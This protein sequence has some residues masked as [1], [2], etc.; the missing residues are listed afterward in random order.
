[1]PIH[2]NILLVL[3]LQF[4]MVLLFMLSQKLNVSYPIFLVIGGLLIGLIPGVPRITLQPDIV[5]LL[6]LPPL[7]YAAAWFTTWHNFWRWRSAI[8]SLA[9]GLVILTS[10]AVAIV[11]T[12][13]IPNF[14]L[15]LGCVLGAIV[16][17]PDAAAAVSVLKGVAIPKRLATI[18]EGESLVN[19]ASSLIVLRFALVAVLTGHFVLQ[20]A[21]T[22]FVLVAAMGI[23]MGLA[24]A[25]VFYCLHRF[26]PTTPSIDVLLT[27]MAPYLM[28][29]TAEQFHFSGVLA[30]VSGGL[31]MSARSHKLF[32][33]QSR[34]QTYSIWDSLIFLV[35]GLV[36]MLI[37][38]QLPS[39]VDGLGQY[40]VREAIFYALV[41]SAATI[42]IRLLYVV[43]NALLPAI[44]SAKERLP[45]LKVVF[46]A[47]W[48]GMRGVVSLA[49]ALAIPLT[50]TNN[51]PFPYRNLIQFITFVV[52]LITLVFQGLSMPFLIR[53]LKVEELDE[54]IPEEQ[55]LAEIRLRMGRLVLNYLSSRYADEVATN[56]KL[57]RFYGDLQLLVGNAQ[58]LLS[59]ETK[60]REQA[61]ID[62]DFD[63]IFLDLT[64]QRRNEL[65]RIRRERVYDT[66]VL[67][68]YERQLDLE[69]AR[70]RL[71]L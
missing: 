36:F 37:G 21:I 38:L 19:D 23:L 2:Y 29:L 12:A 28:Y 11:S 26:L 49:S 13:L 43:P 35:N 60:A 22:D 48:A 10:L 52:I 5:F 18:L 16:S 34:I 59:G 42:V 51:Q 33:Y 15:A 40:S 58:L 7:L 63:R 68:E 31:F 46:L 65:E 69:E 57:N 66:K 62:K 20:R 25:L 47:G 4:A 6:F 55:Q 39:I 71:G 30:V 64:T 9:L 14:T 50:L 45:P 17:P 61:K 24:V 44:F 32:N 56:A 3:A 54:H 70:M 53:W 27:I 8:I 41:I 67:L 1:M